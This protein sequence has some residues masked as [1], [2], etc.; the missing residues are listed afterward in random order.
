VNVSGALVCRRRAS[1]RE[2]AQLARAIAARYGVRYQ[3]DGLPVVWAGTRDRGPGG[4]V[5]PPPAGP[6]G[7]ALTAV[8]L[9]RVEGG[10][11][12][13]VFAGLHLELSLFHA[14]LRDG[15]GSATGA[16][17]AVRVVLAEAVVA[18]LSRLEV[19]DEEDGGQGQELEMRFSVVWLPA[20]THPAA[21]WT[22]L[23]SWS[24]PFFAA[25]VGMLAVTLVA[26]MCVGSTFG[27]VVRRVKLNE[28]YPRTEDARFHWR[29]VA[30]DV[31][32]PPPRPDAL[33]VLT[34]VGV[35]VAA[36]LAGSAVACGLGWM[37]TARDGGL[38]AMTQVPLALFAVT[39]P[40]GGVV[41]TWLRSRWRARADLSPLH[42]APLPL[43]PV[44]LVA[45]CLLP[46]AWSRW[47][48]Q[49]A[50][51]SLPALWGA[52]G[53]AAVSA[54][55][56]AAV[57]A[58]V[59]R[60][61]LSELATAPVAVEA[62]VPPPAWWWER[63]GPQATM[64]GLLV[65]AALFVETLVVGTCWAADLPLPW[66][67]LT[68]GAVLASL[69]LS[70]IFTASLTGLRLFREQHEWWWPAFACP[71]A[72]GAVV[73]VRLCVLGAVAFRL[74]DGAAATLYACACLA[75]CA[76]L[77]LACGGV[78]FMVSLSLVRQAYFLEHSR[79]EHAPD[80]PL[81][82]GA[83]AT[84]YGNGVAGGEGG[85]GEG[86]AGHAMVQ[87]SGTPG[88]GVIVIG[89]GGGGS[90]GG[91]GVAQRHGVGGGEG[92]Q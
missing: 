61:C 45:A 51:F 80:R 65:S 54:C 53:W 28:L 16:T 44:V 91:S 58:A 60:C 63:T 41:L 19:S 25:R 52:V 49:V 68:A 38:A 82:P 32:R 21:R 2:V 73:F 17:P 37:T 29:N 69:W 84:L 9:G 11:G 10:D 55:P 72:T 35:H 77:S 89:G 48:G 86:G 39:A 22:P 66:P 31:F 26:M 1:G 6:Y 30:Y 74:D 24:D 50:G 76:L 85:V 46:T 3:V 40:A 70:A 36:T 64:V 4:V 90:G 57:G 83:Y 20:D 78:G 59:G 56:L 5:R 87:P 12:G 47:Q 7:S 71:T 8:P 79:P 18:A 92:A 75:A 67:A 27:L 43:A 15:A 23:R 33:A 81:L 42:A 13:G 34:A 88:V 62:A 14:P